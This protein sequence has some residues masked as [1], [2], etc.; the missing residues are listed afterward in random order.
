MQT[1]LPYTDFAESAR[2]LDSSRLGKQRLEA[3]QALRALVLPVYGWSNHPAARMWRGHVPG[4]V[5]Y[6]VAMIDEWTARSNTDA[7]RPFVLE[8]APEVDGVP[9]EDVPMPPWMGDAAFHD[10]HRSNLVRK[11]PEHYREFFPDVADDLPYVWPEPD[12][13][14][15]ADAVAPTGPAIAVLRARRAADLEEWAATGVV[16]LPARSPNGTRSK[17]WRAQTEV[18]AEL[19]AGA[20]LGVLTPDNETVLLARVEEEPT[21]YGPD[22]DAEP[23]PAEEAPPPPPEERPKKRGRAK[24]AEQE[25]APPP[26]PESG[27][28]VRVEFGDELPRGAF[29]QPVLLQDPRV[30]FSAPAPG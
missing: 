4:L 10:S 1:F 3:L 14:Q 19:R 11:L 25:A 5:R 15:G 23:T 6:T 16:T 8:F 20:R 18:F 7:I 13:P 27:L 12:L 9:Q 26:P 24:K 28:R 22:P 29:P 21:R 30:F 17:A 2:V